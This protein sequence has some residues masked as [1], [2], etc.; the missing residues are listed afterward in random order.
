MGYA[1]FCYEM[2]NAYWYYYAH[3]ENRQSNAVSWF[4]AAVR[5]YEGNGEKAVERQRSSL[6]VGIGRFYKRVTAAQIDGSD[7]GMYGEYW[8]QLLSLKALN[9]EHP[10]RDLI[11][12]RMYREIVSRVAE[13]A[14]Y[15][16]DDGVPEA[17]LFAM[18]D[19]IETEL[20][21]MEGTATSVTAEEIASIRRIMDGARRMVN[22]SYK[23]GKGMGE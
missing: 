8:S 2:G 7:A 14:K 4:E 1:D 23:N 9:D 18:L 11:V 13:Y 22:S 6:Y 5:G 19:G 12:L 16:R 21:S 17:E 3:E 15:L 20:L 10:D